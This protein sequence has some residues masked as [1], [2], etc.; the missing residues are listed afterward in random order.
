[1]SSFDT[2]AA[3]A[4][5]NDD[6]PGFAFIATNRDGTFKYAKSFGKASAKEESAKSFQLDT[7]MW[8]ASCTKLLT[9]ICCMQL[10]ERGLVKLDEPVYTH[11]PELENL[12]VLTGIKE[13]GSPIE[14]KQTKPIT[15]RLLLTHSSGLAYDAVHP[16]L[17]AWLKHK[18]RTPATSGKLL[19][20]FD[21]PLVFQ[22]GE[23]WMYGSSLDYAGLLVERVTGQTLEEYMKANLW[24]PLG[25]K[26]MTFFL[27]S[28]PDMKE[29]M[30]DMSWREESGKFKLMSEN[31]PYQ[32]GE[33]A[34]MA[35]CMGGQGL[36]ATAEEYIK[37]V[38]ALLVTDEDEK[39]LKKES[40]EE[41]FKPQL[42][43]ASRG[44]LNM[45]LQD[46]VVCVFFEVTTLLASKYRRSSMLTCITLDKQCHG[47][48]TTVYHKGLGSGRCTSHH[49]CTGRKSSRNDDLGWVA[50]LGVGKSSPSFMFFFIDMDVFQR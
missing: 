29:R 40:V 27:S 5:A 6:V 20:R 43:E 47:W 44:M 13:D 18:N 48:R 49:G 21:V 26:D 15:L 9:S 19:S 46:P 31:L 2:L 42:G 33:G 30:A 22:P 34:E 23:S 32:D 10:V 25:I 35:D 14:E 12:P 3:T 36:F 45:I 41:F 7:V 50:K 38:R 16:L 1:M 24:E 8:V 37:I 39:I 28:R 11:I 17:L 4:L